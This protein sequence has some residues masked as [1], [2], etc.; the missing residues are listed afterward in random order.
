MAT[1]P[2]GS[3]TSAGLVSALSRPSCA[4]QAAQVGSPDIDGIRCEIR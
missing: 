2:A 4:G 3:P 1:N